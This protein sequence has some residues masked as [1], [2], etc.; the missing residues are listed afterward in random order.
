MR[1]I[2]IND[3]GGKLKS[4]ILNPDPVDEDIIIRG[5]SQDEILGVVISSEAYE[6]FLRAIEEEEDRLDSESI[7]EF[8]LE[9]K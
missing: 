8:H 7:E 1:E 4:M 5:E 6:F 2:S 3:L 9:R